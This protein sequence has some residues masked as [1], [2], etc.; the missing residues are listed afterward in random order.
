MAPR[1][2]KEV[3][4]HNVQIVLEAHKRGAGGS[5]QDDLA[6]AC[7]HGVADRVD[8]KQGDQD[9]HRE[10]RGIRIARLAGFPTH[11]DGTGGQPHGPSPRPE[12]DGAD[13][14]P[15]SPSTWRRT[16]AAPAEGSPVPAGPCSSLSGIPGP[17]GPSTA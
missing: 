1:A 12:P 13:I 10:N 8:G 3:A 17:A 11:G 5:V 16:P 4:P 6:Q 9:H 7:G 14:T 15:S 2:R